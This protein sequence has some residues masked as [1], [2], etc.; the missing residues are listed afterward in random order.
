VTEKIMTVLGDKDK[1]Q[2]VLDKKA[3]GDLNRLTGGADA[4]T[5]TE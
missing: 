1:V 2:D 5:E 3:E 4:N